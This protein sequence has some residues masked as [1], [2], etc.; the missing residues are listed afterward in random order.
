MP[1]EEDKAKAR[2]TGRKHVLLFVWFDY[3]LA[4]EK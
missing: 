1:S 3:I 4:L 2:K